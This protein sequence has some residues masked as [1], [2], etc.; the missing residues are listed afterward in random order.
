MGVVYL[1]EDTRL[2]RSV[3]IKFL[4]HTYFEDDQAV[5]RFQREAKAAAALN[6]PHICT[7]YDIGES[8]GQPYL[9][10]EHLEGETLKHRLAAGPLPTEEVLKLGVQMADALQMA[11]QKGIIHRD[12]KPANIFV[13]KRGDAKVLDFGLAKQLGRGIE[14]EEDLSTA[15]TLAGS[16]L[17]TLNYMSPEQVKGD[18]LDARTDIFSLGVVLYEMVTGVHPF[19]RKSPMETAVAIQVETVAPLIRYNEEVPDLLQHTV[20]KMLAKAPDRRYQVVHDVRTN[21]QQLVEGSGEALSATAV[22]PAQTGSKRR[23]FGWGWLQFL[24]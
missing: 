24:S 16:T 8:D 22:V 2:E 23:S 18:V 20:T 6:H 15:L 1:A 3:A 19:R 4:P 14:V 7:V 21:L 11:H 13:T 5:K 12:I 17:G 9:V 10:M